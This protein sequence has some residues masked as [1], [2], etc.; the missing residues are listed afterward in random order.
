MRLLSPRQAHRFHS[1]ND[2]DLLVLLDYCLLGKPNGE[3]QFYPMKSW[4]QHFIIYSII[5]CKFIA[6]IVCLFEKTSI[7]FPHQKFL[8]SHLRPVL[9]NYVT[10]RTGCYVCILREMQYRPAYTLVLKHCIFHHLN[11]TAP[12]TEINYKQRAPRLSAF[13]TPVQCTISSH[14]YR[15]FDRGQLVDYLVV[16]NERFNLHQKVHK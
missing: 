6:Y 16:F 8:N 1:L 4:W 5:Y 12:L 2:C 13:C 15:S 9:R 10:V 11:T 14:W 3:R 7:G